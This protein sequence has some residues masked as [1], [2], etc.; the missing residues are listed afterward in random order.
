MII[1]ESEWRLRAKN[2]Q[3]KV[4]SLIS[5]WRQYKKNAQKHPTLDF[6][7]YYYNLKATRL[8]LWS[9]GAGI[10]LE[11]THDANLLFGYYSKSKN[12]FEL[13]PN[14]FPLNRI[15]TFRWTNKLL[16]NTASQTPVF[17]CYGVHEWSM[18]YKSQS[19]RHEQLP[20]RISQDQLNSFVENTPCNCTHFDAFRFFTKDA[21]PLIKHPL[22]RDNQPDYEQS[23]CLH[24]NMDLYKWA[25]KVFPFISADILL[26]CFELAIQCRYLDMQASPYD[27][28]EFKME[29]IEVNLSSGREKY[30]SEQHRL[31]KIADPLR[32]KLSAAYKNFIEICDG[33]NT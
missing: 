10:E 30:I 9:P 23:A 16:E 18:I 13:N 33:L 4:D 21:K 27:L 25:Y 1:S 2:H 17:N 20:L 31:K 26:E 7:F 12:G 15:N 8:R 28:S 11:G 29:P 6:L 24:A 22:N 19:K 14:K 3:S 32:E 5:E